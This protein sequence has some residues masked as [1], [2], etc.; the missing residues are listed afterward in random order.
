MFIGAKSG[1]DRGTGVAAGMGAAFDGATP[2]DKLSSTA[3]AVMEKME[4]FIRTLIR[5]RS[6]Y[7]WGRCVGRNQPNGRLSRYTGMKACSTRVDGI[8]RLAIALRKA[9]IQQIFNDAIAPAY[10]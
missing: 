4:C 5:A 3:R 7:Q 8:S 10:C 2:N 6:S 9:F 1:T